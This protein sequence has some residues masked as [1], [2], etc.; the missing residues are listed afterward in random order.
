MKR[1]LIILAALALGACTLTP[2][3]QQAVIAGT[4]CAAETALAVNAAVVGAVGATDAEKAKVAALTA[5]TV[6]AGN[7]DCQAAGAAAFAAATSK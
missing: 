7:K 5:A 2:T 3:Q 1:S 6:A 4:S